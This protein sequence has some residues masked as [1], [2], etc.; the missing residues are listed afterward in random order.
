MK[1]GFTVEYEKEL[2]RKDGS[3]IPVSNRVWA[4]FDENKKPKAMWGILR[5]VTERKRAEQRF[6]ESQQKFAALFNGNP[7]ATAYTDPDMHILDIN[8]RFT[9]LFGY[10]LDEVKENTSMTL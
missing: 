7:E 3:T 10:G 1:K 8:P 9:S 6:L 5:D 2:I 4:T